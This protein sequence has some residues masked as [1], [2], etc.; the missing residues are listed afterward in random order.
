MN[1]RSFG[2]IP[3]T[4]ALLGLAAC[5]TPSRQELA[6]GDPLE[7]VNR[8]VHGFNEAVARHVVTPVAGAVES[9]TSDSGRN[10]AGEALYR[11]GNVLSNLGEPKNAVNGAL[12]GNIGTVGIAVT[13]FGINSTLGLLGAY[14]VAS[15]VGLEERREDFGQTL[16]VWGVAPGPYVVAPL[17]GPSSTRD[18]TGMVVDTVINPVSLLPG[19]GAVNVANTGVSAVGAVDSATE[20]AAL[21][22]Q[23]EDSYLAA[24][25]RYEARRA[26]L[27]ANAPQ[28]ASVSVYPPAMDEDD[29][30]MDM[31]PRNPG[32]LEIDIHPLPAASRVE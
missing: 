23:D 17:A 11:V 2:L 22:E 32:A 29:G 4:A 9:S 3:C 19:A 27:I 24:R 13:R 26:A 25:N 15:G 16:G 30:A 18:V 7:G 10:T 5:A 12:Q 8:G 6:E 20:T 1:M 28:T 21:A 14:D 31:E